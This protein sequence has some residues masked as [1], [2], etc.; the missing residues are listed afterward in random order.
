MEIYIILIKNNIK[1]I[2]IDFAL[3]NKGSLIDISDEKEYYGLS[4]I[5]I[6]NVGIHGL[7][8]NNKVIDLKKVID[9]IKRKEMLIF[10]IKNVYSS[11]S[12][13]EKDYFSDDSL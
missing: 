3:S 13:E 6:D 8:I 1:Q 2:S 9:D 7:D 4:I 5:E 11:E 10:D 12:L